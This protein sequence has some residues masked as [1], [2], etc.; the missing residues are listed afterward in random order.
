MGL[1]CYTTKVPADQSASEIQ[2]MLSIRGATG[3]LLEYEQGTG[4]IDRIAFKMRMGEQE[5]GFRLPLRWRQ[6]KN[7]LI[8]DRTIENSY[9]AR[10]AREED[11]CYRVAWRILREWVDAQMAMVDLRMV[12]VQEVFLPYAIMRDDKTLFENM[13]A[14]PGRLLA[15]RGSDMA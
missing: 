15:Q 11:Y 12:Q 13:A 9:R 2:K 6:V 8:E 10:A 4:R 14:N 5:I 1:K 7:A 3:I